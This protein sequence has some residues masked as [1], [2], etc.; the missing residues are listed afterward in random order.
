M[1]IDY[2]DSRWAKWP[3]VGEDAEYKILSS[4]KMESGPWEYNFKRGGIDVGYNYHI[5]VED[6]SGVNGEK[7]LV[8]NNW[9]IF[10]ALKEANVQDGMNIIVKHPAKGVWKVHVLASKS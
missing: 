5:R 7:I 3:A 2:R 10:Y 6:P 9:S 4:E 8:L 1:P